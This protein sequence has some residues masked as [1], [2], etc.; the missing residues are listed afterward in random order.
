M[1]PGLLAEGSPKMV[2]LNDERTIRVELFSRDIIPV[3][4]DGI[5]LVSTMPDEGNEGP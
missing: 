1:P 5:I 2:P 4:T 3:I